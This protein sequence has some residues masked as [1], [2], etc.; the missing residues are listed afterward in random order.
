MWVGRVELPKT[1]DTRRYRWATSKDRNT[2]L[3][4]LKKLRAEVD[5]GAIA[6]TGHTTVQKWLDRWM[7][8]IHSKRIR[9]TT[10]YSYQSIITNNINPAIG[11]K[12][13]DRL[14]PAHVREMHKAIGPTRTCFLAHTIL[15]KSLKDAMREGMVT[16]NVCSLVDKPTYAK[17]KRTELSVPVVKRI[18]NASSDESQA[19]RWAAAF[20]TGARQGELLGL[21]W[22]YID[23]DDGVMDVS[24]QLQQLPKFHGCGD[25]VNDV[26]PCGMKYAGNCPKAEWDF[27]PDFEYEICRGSLVWTKPKTDAGVRVVPLQNVLLERLD[28][29]YRNQGPNPHDLVWHHPDGRAIAPRE[30]YRMWNELL[31]RAAVV[32]KGKTLPLHTARHT[33]ATLLRKAGVSEQDRMELLGQTDVDT[34]RGYAH[35]DL[36]RHKAAMDHIPAL[37]Q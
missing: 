31:I 11:T 28:V 6:V 33:T 22:P 30:D 9:P 26:Y 16:R 13:L 4:K 32:E 2:A 37:L 36:L 35:S 8:D 18:L 7:T 21:R 10:R 1:G 15:A 34:Q 5:S 17:K 12:R 19:T 27:N 14:T 20:F 25:P 3:A 24:W 29:L 23:W